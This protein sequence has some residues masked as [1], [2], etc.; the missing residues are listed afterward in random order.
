MKRQREQTEAEGHHDQRIGN[1]LRRCGQGTKTHNR[2]NE[3]EQA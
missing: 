2:S 1:V 3:Q